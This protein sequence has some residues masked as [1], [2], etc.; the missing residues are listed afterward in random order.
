[1]KT[2]D[3]YRGDL[4][5]IVIAGELDAWLSQRPYDRILISKGSEPRLLVTKH[6]KRRQKLRVR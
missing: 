4:S 6:G 3:D 1:M 5:A 2:S